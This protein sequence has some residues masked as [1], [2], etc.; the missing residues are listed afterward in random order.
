MRELKLLCAEVKGLDHHQTYPVSCA[1]RRAYTQAVTVLRTSYPS[2]H[3]CRGCRHQVSGSTYFLGFLNL[4]F[5]ILTL[6]IVILAA[7][8]EC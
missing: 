5:H 1:G 8:V 2:Q 3:G 6:L 7:F 4:N